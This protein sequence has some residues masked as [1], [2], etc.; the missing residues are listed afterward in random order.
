MPRARRALVVDDNAEGR[1]LLA[2]F[3]DVSGYAVSTACTGREAL[4]TY[5]ALRPDL[6]FLDIGM[7]ELDG[8]E[9]CS[10]LRALPSGTEATIYAVTGFGSDQH[11]V[12]SVQAGFNGHFVKPLDLD[13]LLTLLRG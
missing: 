2:T 11:R 13:A 6:I 1:E 9:V 7:P 8:Y 12:R 3:L 10:R 4:E 5:V